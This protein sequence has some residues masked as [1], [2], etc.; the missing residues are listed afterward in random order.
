[1]RL[2]WTDLVNPMKFKLKNLILIV[3]YVC[4]TFYS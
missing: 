4:V 2:I 1:M 3:M